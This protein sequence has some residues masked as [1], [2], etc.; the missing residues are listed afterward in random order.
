MIN[1]I[2]KSFLLSILFVGLAYA[3]RVLFKTDLYLSDVGGLGSF[4]TVFGTLYGIMSAFVVFEVWAQFNRTSSLV[5]QEA[6]GL[7]RLFRLT[8]YF[9]DTKLTRDMAKAITAYANKVIEGKFQKL[10][11]GVRNK[12][13]GLL[14]RNISEV[15]REVKFDDEHDAIVYGQVLDHYGKLGQIRTDRTN[16]SLTRLPL[17][18]KV[19]LYVTSGVAVVTFVAMPFANF[20]YQAF[21]IAGIGFVIAMMISLVEDLDNP[22][23][24]N[25]N[26]TPEPFARALKH[27]E[28]DYK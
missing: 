19:F 26:I 25:W 9:R 22:F 10:G 2:T 1:V 18:L 24:G 5:D 17:L 11:S 23:V 4:V 7:E 8:L 6:L 16:Q 12:E 3:V 27:I 14:F 15:I 13:S 21:V 28:E 20:V